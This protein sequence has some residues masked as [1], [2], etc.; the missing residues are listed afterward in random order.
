MKL[1][2]QVVK[3][4]PIITGV[5]PPADEIIELHLWLLGIFLICT[6]LFGLFAIFVHKEGKKSK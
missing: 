4:L 6:L 1:Y 3:I 2:A 5:T